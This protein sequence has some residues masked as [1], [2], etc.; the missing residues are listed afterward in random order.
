MHISIVVEMRRKINLYA[1][2]VRAL[3]SMLLIYVPPD[4]ISPIVMSHQA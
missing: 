2:A 4:L 3:R 1:L